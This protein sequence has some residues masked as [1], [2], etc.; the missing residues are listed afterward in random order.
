MGTVTP[1]YEGWK[2]ERMY[3]DA[4]KALYDAVLAALQEYTTEGQ[5]LH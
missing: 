2:Y 1:P 3:N 4:S 5:L